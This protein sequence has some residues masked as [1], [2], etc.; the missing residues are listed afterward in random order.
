MLT[1]AAFSLLSVAVAQKVGRDTPENHPKLNWKQCTTSGCQNVN[2][3]VVIDANW[4]W[5]HNGNFQNCYDG[6]KWT[7]VC[8]SDEECTEI[9]HA[10]G[11]RYAENYGV[12]SSGDS[13]RLAFTKEHA[14][15]K[16]VGSRM[17]LMKDEKTYQHFDLIGNELAFDVDLSTVAC[18]LNSALYFVAMPADGGM[19]TQPNNKAGAKYGTGY[20][21]A[22]CAR[23]LKFLGGSANMEGWKPSESDGS[24]GVGAKGA[25][26]AEIDVWESNSAAFALTPHACENN[27]YHICED[28]VGAGCGGTY[29]E[30]RYAGLCDANGCDYNPY[31]MGNPD[32]YGRGK[33]VD[34]TKKFTVVT[35][36]TATDL[37]QFFIQNGQRIDIPTPKFDN[38][39][40]SSK[41]TQELC[42]GLFNVFD[43]F[44]RYADVGGWPAM[45]DA[46]SVPHVLVLSIWADHY[47][48]MLWLDGVWPRGGDESIP[49]VVRGDCPADSG[50]PSEVEDEHADAYVNWSNIRFGPIGSTTDFS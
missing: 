31:R 23:D 9:C 14:Y 48:N 38:L 2:G 34:T 4:R 21:D 19:S 28:G 39:P 33:T 11:A 24:A 17:Y 1:L 8:S 29:S 15:G 22:Q 16:N 35:Q 47:A 20:C 5:F 25:C 10:E 40:N 3:E 36:F 49:G 37:T 45:V 18:G 44:D 13:L 26:C 42:D 32:F 12:T 30:E 6:N 41:I 50:V 46:L 27:D 43:E 7:S